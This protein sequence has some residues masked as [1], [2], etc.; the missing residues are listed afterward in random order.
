[1]AFAEIV[2]GSAK[3]HDHID[4]RASDAKGVGFTSAVV[5][6][7]VVLIYG[8]TPQDVRLERFG[9][10][11][12]V[13]VFMSEKSGRLDVVAHELLVVADRDVWVASKKQPDIIWPVELKVTARS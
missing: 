8:E 4:E 3:D 7:K 10:E 2:R 12:R 13:D 1:M 5:L 11:T 6:T 9:M